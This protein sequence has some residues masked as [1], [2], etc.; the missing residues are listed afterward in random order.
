MAVPEE[1]GGC[2][3]GP[4]TNTLMQMQGAG[5]GRERET[6]QHPGRN[7][8]SAAKPAGKERRKEEMGEMKMRERKT[9]RRG[10]VRAVMSPERQRGWRR[11]ESF[12]HLSSVTAA[13]EDCRT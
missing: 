12:H 9:R 1:G 5:R 2:E 3:G 7:C 13:R 11:R 6:G 8:R 4:S 10:V